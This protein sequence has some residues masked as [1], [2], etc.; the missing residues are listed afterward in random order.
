MIFF[1]DD[2]SPLELPLLDPPI[3]PGVVVEVSDPMVE[4]L[5]PEEVETDVVSW[6]E[7]SVVTTVIVL[8]VVCEATMGTMEV[9]L[10]AGGVVVV[11]VLGGG[12]VVVVPFVVVSVV[13][14]GGGEDEL[15]GADGVVVSVLVPVTT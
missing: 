4:L 12:V 6:P 10:E 7:E 13:E 5:T 8:M 9:D 3:T 14:G 1:D 15:V 2:D 11:L